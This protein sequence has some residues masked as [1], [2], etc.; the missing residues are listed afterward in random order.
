MGESFRSRLLRW[1]FNL[2]PAYRG[3][4]GRIRYISDDFREV[5]IE[6][7]LSWRTRNYV[8]TIFGGSLYGAV[9]PIYMIQL[10]RILGEGYTVW[11]RAA[12]IRFVKPGRSKLFARCLV[13]EEEIATIRSLCASQPSVDRKYN[14][15]IVNA[16]GVIHATVEKTIY[17]RSKKSVES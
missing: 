4:G 7:P 1:K 6:I 11:D 17:V 12:A 14:I 10:I 3:T 2:F 15:D 16:E 9:D 5:R 13:T 8:G